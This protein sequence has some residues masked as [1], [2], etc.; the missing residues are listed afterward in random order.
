MLLAGLALV[1]LFVWHALRT[2]HPLI[3]VRLFTQRGFATAAATNLVLG[4]ALFGV[5]SCCPSTSRSSAAP[6]HCRPAC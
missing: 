1:A 3:D 4:V 6:A 2:A 5:A